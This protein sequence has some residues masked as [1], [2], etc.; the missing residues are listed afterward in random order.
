MSFTQVS[1]NMDFS[2]TKIT[3]GWRLLGFQEILMLD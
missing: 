1:D 3:E 2:V